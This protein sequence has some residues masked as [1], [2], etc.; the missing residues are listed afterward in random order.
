M[1]VVLK[2]PVTGW[3]HPLPFCFLISPYL[4]IEAVPVNSCLEL[5]KSTCED[6]LAY[7][8]SSGKKLPLLLFFSPAVQGTEPMSLSKKILKKWLFPYTFP[9]PLFTIF[10]KKKTKNDLEIDCIGLVVNYTGLFLSVILRL[11]KPYLTRECL[12]DG[13]TFLWVHQL[14]NVIL[15]WNSLPRNF[16]FPYI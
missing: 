13:R 12:T 3:D 8:C 14:Y 1:A 4:W 11:P 7:R 16:S 6:F 5:K 9:C 15:S 10:F 2:I